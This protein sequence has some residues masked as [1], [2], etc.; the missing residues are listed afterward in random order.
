MAMSA[1]GMTT[2]RKLIAS[3]EINEYTEPCVP[4]CIDAGQ[5]EASERKADGKSARKIKVN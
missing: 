2:F 4:I 5:R 1:D 3:A